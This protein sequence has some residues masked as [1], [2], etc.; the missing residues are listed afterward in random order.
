MLG[1]C[2]C[3]RDALLRQ[4]ARLA[5][6]PGWTGQWLIEAGY[7]DVTKPPYNADQAGTADAAPAIQRAIADGYNMSLVV[8]VPKGTY[9]IGSPLVQR[10]IEGF[11]RCGSNRKHG[12]LLVGDT[13]ARSRCSRPWTERSPA[14]RS[15]PRNLSWPMV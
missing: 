6:G 12:N 8:Y 9:L 3:R 5:G 13:A 2:L 1:A 15:T 14:R 4:P 10:Q 7:L 11:S